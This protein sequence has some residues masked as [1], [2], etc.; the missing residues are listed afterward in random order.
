MLTGKRPFSADTPG[1]LFIKHATEAPPV[2]TSLNPAISPAANQLVMRL[3]KKEPKQRFETY[4]DLLSA[5]ES[6]LKSKGISKSKAAPGAAGRA[7]PARRFPW[8]GAITGVA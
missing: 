6:A 3:L 1:A 4:D 5:I 2:A 8:A 7:L